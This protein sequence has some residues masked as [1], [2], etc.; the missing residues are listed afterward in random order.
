ME[1]GYYRKTVGEI[2]TLLDGGNNDS[3]VPRLITNTT[4]IEKHTNQ[5]Q[6]SV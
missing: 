4:I 6:S 3:E 2:R 1:N 5:E